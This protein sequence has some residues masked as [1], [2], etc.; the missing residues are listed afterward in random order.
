MAQVKTEKNRAYTIKGG[1]LLT[2]EDCEALAVEFEGEQDL[3]VWRRHYVGRPS[4]ESGVSPRVSFRASRKLY[5]AAR[6]RAAQEG[7]TVSELAR[8]AVERYLSLGVRPTKD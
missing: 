4:L 7:R 5:D 3:S 6:E 1:A 2:E 8:E